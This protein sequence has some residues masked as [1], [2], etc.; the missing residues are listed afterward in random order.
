MQILLAMIG[1]SS[2]GRIV[3]W[4]R[5]PL[6]SPSLRR[7]QDAAKS[8]FRERVSNYFIVITWMALEDC[9][10][11]QPFLLLSARDLQELLVGTFLPFFP[12]EDKFIWKWDPFGDFSIRTAYNLLREPDHTI[13]W[14]EV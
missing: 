7:L 1:I 3:G 4:E 8:F 2:F 9:C 10:I 12:R 11:D 13:N 6:L 14:K 5:S